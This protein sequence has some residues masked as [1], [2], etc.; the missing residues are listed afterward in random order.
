MKTTDEINEET[1]I[2]GQCIVDMYIDELVKKYQ[3][4]AV[5]KWSALPFFIRKNIVRSNRYHNGGNRNWLMGA[6]G[7]AQWTT[8]NPNNQLCDIAVNEF[9]QQ[10]CPNEE[11]VVVVFGDHDYDDLVSFVQDMLTDTN[12]Q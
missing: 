8:N 6:F 11:C 12:T 3:A 2:S 7:E 5:F 4:G 10:M 9:F 1:W